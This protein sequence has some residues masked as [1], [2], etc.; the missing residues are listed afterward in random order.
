MYKTGLLSAVS[1][2]LPLSKALAAPG[3]AFVCALVVTV[4]QN[5]IAL[6][7]GTYILTHKTHFSLQ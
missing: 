1:V 4:L 2:K 7:V 5:C 3:P 6:L